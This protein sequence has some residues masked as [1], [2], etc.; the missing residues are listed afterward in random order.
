M[1][2]F[3]VLSVLAIL[4][5]VVDAKGASACK[6]AVKAATR[7]VQSR[8]YITS[9]FGDAGTITAWSGGGGPV[10]TIPT[11]NGHPF[12]GRKYGGAD[13]ST[14]YGSRVYGSGYP[15]G[16]DGSGSSTSNNNV[17]TTATT[18]RGFPYG[19]WPISWNQDEYFSQDVLALR[20]GGQLVSAQVGSTDTNKWPGLPREERYTIVG[21]MDS[22]MFMMSNLV[23]WC[24]V[25]MDWPKT[26]G[27]SAG[28]GEQN[29]IQYYRA[30]SFALLFT[31]YNA[32]STASNAEAFPPLPASIADSAFLQCVN[33]TIGDSIPILDSAASGDGGL[34]EGATIGVVIACVVGAVA[35]IL[36]IGRALDKWPE[37]K[38]SIKS[39]WK[40]IAPAAANA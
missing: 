31:G 14:I 28:L 22:V 26:L 25:T 11:D 3:P 20:P 35:L 34:S 6:S 23:G 21:D 19:M 37:W 10:S 38:E 40:R 15:S 9:S 7:N 30:S 27:S 13:R 1:T 12:G 5:S 8:V 16:Y 36:C 33:H 4:F 29:V 39:W 24:S 32:T 17:T 18:G 2:L